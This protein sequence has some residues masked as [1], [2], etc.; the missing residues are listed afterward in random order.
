MAGISSKAA[1][2]LI[3]RKKFNGKEEQREEFSDGSGLEWLDY[4]ARMM[5][6]QI[7]R[8]MT[9]DP[10]AEKMR[11]WSPYVYAFD[12][13]I[14]FID[15]DG[16]APTDVGDKYKSKDA[17]AA[18]WSAQY[19]ASS[20]ANGR[21]LGS[22]IYSSKGKDGKTYYSYNAPTIGEQGKNG[23]YSVEW[24]QK[25]EK[26]QKL[27]GV[28]HSHVESKSSE[29]GGSGND[30]SDFKGRKELGVK[31]D[32]QT[33]NDGAK[34]YGK[35]DWFLAAPDGTLKKATADGEGGHTKG[36]EIASGFASE[37]KV[38][39]YKSKGTKVIIAPVFSILWTGSKDLTPVEKAPK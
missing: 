9:I 35:V 14:R 5:D 33:M 26:G 24:N 3:N 38:E 16:M 27:E 39:D 30:F 17:A 21:E 34:D 22:S 18:A 37:K 23:N 36:L 8:W 31:G 2:T 11:R 13:P 32:V 15:N 7:G 4:G 6:N 20:I 1:G 28:V 19:G 25:L 12:N 10:L 29:F